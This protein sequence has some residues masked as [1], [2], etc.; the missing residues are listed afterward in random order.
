MGQPPRRLSPLFSEALVYAAQLHARQ[1]RK[2]T[3]IPYLSHPLS[4]AALVL[5]HGG[6]EEEAIAGLLHDA[7]EDQG[8]HRRL[9]EIEKLFGR[10]VAAIVRGCSDCLGDP[11]PDW[12]TRKRRYIAGLRHAGPKVLRVVAA[13]KLHN[14]RA[15]LADFR[16]HGEAVFDRFKGR[17]RGTLWYYAR[18]ARV[19]GEVNGGVLVEE[20][21]RVVAELIDGTRSAGRPAASAAC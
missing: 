18:V 14:A 19:L 13:D 15:I 4:V 20:L 10:R 17:K 8:G 12:F 1:P 2:G 6:T 3:D 11:K 16:G 9:E 5:E 21:Q 7:A